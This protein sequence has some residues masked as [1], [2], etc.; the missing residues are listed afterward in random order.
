MIKRNPTF[1]R[2]IGKLAR[3]TSKMKLLDR[4]FNS[5]ALLFSKNAHSR[6]LT[7]SVICW[8][9]GFGK[10]YKLRADYNEFTARRYVV[11]AERM[12]LRGW[13]IN[14]KQLDYGWN[15]KQIEKAMKP[16]R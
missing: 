1:I 15:L 9:I 2:K 8:I 16:K 7:L 4:F 12:R 5:I 10:W 13:L 6:W 3:L 11:A 14:Y